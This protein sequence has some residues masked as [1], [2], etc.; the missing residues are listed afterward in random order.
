MI[1]P[2][3]SVACQSLMEVATEEEGVVVRVDKVGVGG[4]Q[5]KGVEVGGA[6]LH[7]DAS[8]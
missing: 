8:G 7:D 2:D 3:L 6:G 1:C 4:T 5:D